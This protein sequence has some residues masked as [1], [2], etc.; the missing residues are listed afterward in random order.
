MRGESMKRMILNREHEVLA[1]LALGMV[2]EVLISPCQ[3]Y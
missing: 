2:I 1:F 3:L